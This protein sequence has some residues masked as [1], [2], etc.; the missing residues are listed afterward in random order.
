MSSAADRVEQAIQNN[1][2]YLKTVLHKFCGAGDVEAVKYLLETNP[3][4]DID[5]ASKGKNTAL[6][7]ALS[8]NQQGEIIDYLIEKG[9]NVNA[10]NT[11]GF[12]P[13]I[14]S[15]IH[16]R[17]GTR[18][19]QKLIDAGVDYKA[20]FGR[21]KFSG[22]TPLDLASVHKNEGI[23]TLLNTLIAQDNEKSTCVEIGSKEERKMEKS[24]KTKNHD[25]CPICKCCVKF[26]MK[27]SFLER[28]QVYAERKWQERNA[29]R[30]NIIEEKQ[31]QDASNQRQL[32]KEL[33]VSRKYL[34]EFLNHN[35]GLAFK[36]LCNIKYHG[37]GNK[38]KLRK[39]LTESYSILH[40]VQDC[41]DG[42]DS[43]N[44]EGSNS[45][46]DF[47]NVFLIDLC[48]GKS[49]TT[50][51][52]GALFPDDGE[53]RN[54]HFLAV[55]RLPVHLVPHFMQDRHTSYL[56][57]DIMLQDF[58]Q[59][60]K[61]EVERQSLQGRRAILVGMHLCGNLSVKAIQIF[62]SIPLLKG[63]ILSPCCL[64]KLRKGVT[65]FV[66]YQKK[67]GSVGEDPYIVWGRYLEDK[68]CELE[69]DDSKLSVR[70]FSDENIH[71]IKN[72][73]ITCR[74]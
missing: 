70:R 54:N 53:D 50:A 18:A 22:L 2:G 63:L 26:P 16:C 28:D 33:Y 55:D 5:V 25:T 15:I 34:D 10:F 51:L 3:N 4:L 6:H 65:D 27:V 56:S 42:V 31:E 46:L 62:E 17:H 44:K 21:G 29:T 13:L 48:S 11:K 45:D 64:P 35:G 71:S 7:T 52:C 39:E 47:R 40:A 24:K 1:K 9:A 49:L 8:H 68:A 58:L 19:L 73:I 30:T 41:C 12:N 74:R 67:F 57:R 72:T 38:N 37:I 61:Q 69:N 66:D 60:L 43:S 36:K 59:E 14:L 20:R 32:E 23:Q